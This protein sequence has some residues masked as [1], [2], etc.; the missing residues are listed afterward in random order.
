[1]KVLKH[2]KHGKREFSGSQI[3]NATNTDFV[4]MSH[5][6]SKTCKKYNNANNIPI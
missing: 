4:R 3:L 2:Q 1:M 6:S 5:K